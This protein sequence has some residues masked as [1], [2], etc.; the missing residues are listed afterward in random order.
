MAAVDNADI[1]HQGPAVSP[2]HALANARCPGDCRGASQAGFTMIELIVTIVILGI[3]S[4]YAVP[5]F[6][7]MRT[8]AEAASIARIAATLTTASSMNQARCQVTSNQADGS[9][10]VAVTNCIDVANT[11][12]EGLPSTLMGEPGSS[13]YIVSQVISASANGTAVDCTLRLDDSR[14]NTLQ[15]AVFRGIASGL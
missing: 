3:L 9:K 12:Q 15:T 5:R 2:H 8:E 6:L 4:A 10:C 11:L 13:L 7:D 1:N 14:G